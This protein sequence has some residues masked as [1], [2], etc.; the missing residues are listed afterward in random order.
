MLRRHTIAAIHVTLGLCV[1]AARAVADSDAVDGAPAP[2]IEKI[3]FTVGVWDTTAKYRFTPEAT[4]F[5]SKSVETVQ[6]SPNR[7]FLISDQRS[8]MPAGPMNQLV[9]TTWN[10]AS[11]E[12]RLVAVMQDGQVTE[13][14]MTVEGNH[15]SALYYP[16]VDGR[17]VRAEMIYDYSSHTEY[18]F[19]EERTDQGKTWIYCEGTSRKRPVNASNQAMQLTAS[20]LVVHALSVCHPRFPLR[21]DRIGLAAA[22]LV[23][24]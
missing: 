22:D 9:I 3:A 14:G 18:T 23:S 24:R 1:L 5:E 2:E 11:K 21:R 12:Y 17:L 19:R 4:V 6:W 13:T 10:S 8:L 20:K 16:R 15:R 7:Q